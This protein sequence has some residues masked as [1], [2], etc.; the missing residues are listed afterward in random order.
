MTTET[1]PTLSALSGRRRPRPGGDVVGR[2]PAPLGG[3]A[4]GRAALPGPGGG[5][6][7]E[8]P[9]QLGGGRDEDGRRDADAGVLQESVRAR[10]HPARHAG[11]GP[12]RDPLDPERYKRNSF[13]VLRWVLL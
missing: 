6:R 1:D 12:R 7:Q 5:A 10:L 11:D 2:G 8:A 4:Q 9:N 13:N 3:P